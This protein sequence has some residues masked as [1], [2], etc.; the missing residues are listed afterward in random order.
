MYTS[1]STNQ[2]FSMDMLRS[3]CQAHNTHQT[4][5]LAY[6]FDALP[7]AYLRTSTHQTELLVHVF[8][9][10]PRAR[11]QNLDRDS[12]LSC[13]LSVTTQDYGTGGPALRACLEWPPYLIQMLLLL[14]FNFSDSRYPPP[15]HHCSSSVTLRQE[16]K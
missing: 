13:F 1:Y 16:K 8:D 5:R 2:T 12:Y 11:K 6:L 7:R 14:F 4:E 15:L 9:I 10:L 3:I